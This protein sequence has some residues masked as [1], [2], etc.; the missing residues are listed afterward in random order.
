[1]E[2]GEAAF[3]SPVGQKGWSNRAEKLLGL[4][5][6]PPLLSSFSPS[7]RAATLPHRLI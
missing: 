4:G 1:M 3:S 6:L 2:G 7:P 5:R